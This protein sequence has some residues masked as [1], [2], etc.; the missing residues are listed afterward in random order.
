M[1]EDLNRDLQT[2]VLV[3]GAGPAGCLAAVEER[4]SA[5]TVFSRIAWKF[6]KASA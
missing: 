6:W 3:V 5:E 1:G 2:D 4:R